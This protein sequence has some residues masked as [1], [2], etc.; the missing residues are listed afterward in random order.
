MLAWKAWVQLCVDR[1]GRHRGSSITW[2]ASDVTVTWVVCTGDCQQ[3]AEANTRLHPW[4]T[5]AQQRDPQRTS[6]LCHGPA[7][8]SLRVCSGLIKKGLTCTFGESSIGVFFGLFW[9]EKMEGA[10]EN[11]FA[12]GGWK[13]VLSGSWQGVMLLQ[14]Q[15]KCILSALDALLKRNVCLPVSSLFSSSGR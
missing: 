13:P 4:K 2:V 14:T 6:G 11:D 5:M 10:E 7:L 8:L 12:G 1:A 3:Q 15:G 9:N